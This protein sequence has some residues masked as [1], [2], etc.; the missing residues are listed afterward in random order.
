[1]IKE[2]TNDNQYFIELCKLLEQEHIDVVA[3]QRSPK[4][5]CLKN[6]DKYIHVLLYFDNNDVVGS[7][8]ISGPI[9][10]TVEIGRVYVLP[11]YRN[12]GVARRLFEETF[13]IIKKEGNKRVILNTYERFEAAVYLYRKLGFNIVGPFDDLENSPYSIC[14]EKNL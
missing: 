3:E 7:L 5:N 10:N 9:D 4:G 1:M 2:V 11:K 8:A 13:K 14:M 6:L 12:M